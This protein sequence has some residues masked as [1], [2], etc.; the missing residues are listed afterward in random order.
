ME[1]APPHKEPAGS[2]AHATRQDHRLALTCIS[3]RE[4]GGDTDTFVFG[5]RRDR[6]WPSRRGSSP[7]KLD[8]YASAGSLASC[9]L[10]APAPAPPTR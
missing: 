8:I 6:C 3:Q 5:A 1:S 7:P 10:R 4:K 2:V 9:L